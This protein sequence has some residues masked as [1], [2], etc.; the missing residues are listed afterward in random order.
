MYIPE[1]FRED[2]AERIAALLRAYPF[3]LLICARDGRPQAT[4]LPL[5][6]ET[7][8]SGR[9]WLCGHLARANPQWHELKEGGEALTVFNGPHAYISPRWY[10][11]PGVPTWNYAAVHVR[12]R[13]ELIEDRDELSAL[14]GR[15][16]EAFEEGVIPW[17]WS[18]HAERFD[19]MLEHVVGFRLAVERVEAKFKLGQNRA[20]ADQRNVRERL[21]AS[22]QTE[23]Q[24]LARLMRTI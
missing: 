16:A 18:D 1:H 8:G 6:Y 12:G 20:E 5:L 22:A 13:A 7:D 19:A 11:R 24:A 21:S 17:R 15:M 10:E 14:V 4:H 9:A 3:A 23:A 2:D